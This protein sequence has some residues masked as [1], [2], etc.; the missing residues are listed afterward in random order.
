MNRA[1]LIMILGLFTSVCNASDFYDCSLKKYFDYTKA[2]EGWQIGSTDIIKSHRPSFSEVTDIYMRDQMVLIE[3]NYLAVKLLFS[4]DPDLIKTDKRLSRWLS[5]SRNDESGL[6][7]K[8]KEFGDLISIYNKS[9]KREP[10]PDGD[11]LRSIMRTEI[12]GL[13]EFKKLLSEFNERVNVINS[14]VCNAT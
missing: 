11:G 10:H 9:R 13:P 12:M 7:N 4:L 8:S 14:R 1:V 2:K 5:L 6:A 3:K